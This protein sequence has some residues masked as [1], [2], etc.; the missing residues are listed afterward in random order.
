MAERL[1]LD[2][3]PEKPES[4]QGSPQAI[5]DDYLEVKD[6]ITWL[7]TEGPVSNP[8]IKPEKVIR[9]NYL[10]A[11]NGLS[12]DYLQNSAAILQ[13]RAFKAIEQLNPKNIE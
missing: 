3:A 10:F 4:E 5:V 8:N 7:I 13:K 9:L 12:T 11:R 6:L 2:T 1:P